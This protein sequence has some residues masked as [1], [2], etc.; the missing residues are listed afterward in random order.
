MKTPLEKTDNL[1]SQVFGTDPITTA[2]EVT[3]IDQEGRV[4]AAPDTEETEIVDT[5]TEFARSNMYDLLRQGQDAIEYALQLAKESENPRAFEV[6]F[7]GLKNL[8]DMNSQLLQ[9]QK[10]KQDLKK[11]AAGAPAATPGK[12]VN[13]A[14]FVGTTKDLARMLNGD[15]TKG[16]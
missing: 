6:V 4:V 1:L 16:E 9:L 13:N 8:S 7:A 5:D 2:Q 14:V 10:Q 11:P 15:E 3:V 12:V